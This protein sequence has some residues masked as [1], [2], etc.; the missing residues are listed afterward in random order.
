MSFAG[1]HFCRNRDTLINLTYLATLSSCLVESE[2]ET[3]LSEASSE[4]RILCVK[5]RMSSNAAGRADSA[6]F[7]L[8]DLSIRCEICSTLGIFVDSSNQ[9]LEFNL[10]VSIQES[11]IHSRIIYQVGR[12]LVPKVL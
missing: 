10:N 12:P 5:R 6:E 3:D 9:K 7:V 11:L 8:L 4:A 1:I 2:L